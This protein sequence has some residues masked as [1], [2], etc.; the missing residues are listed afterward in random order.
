[1]PP[2]PNLVHLAV[3]SHET[4]PIAP[5]WNSTPH[6]TSCVI[7]RYGTRLIARSAPLRR[8]RDQQPE[9]RPAQHAEP[10]RDED[11]HERMP[12]QAP[13]GLP[14][15]PAD[16]Y[17]ERHRLDRGEHAKHR[18]LGRQVRGHAAA[19]QELPAPDRLLLDQFAN[20]ADHAEPHRRAPEN[21]HRGVTRDPAEAG[22]H[23]ERRQQRYR[24]P[25]EQAERQRQAGPARSAARSVRRRPCPGR[26]RARATRAT[27][28]AGWRHPSR[29]A[30]LR[31]RGPARQLR[32]VTR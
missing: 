8:R 3:K 20:R 5:S 22:R 26:A 23:R 19:C 18:H 16:H 12:E 2:S 13:N 4:K 6:S 9:G 11:R 28:R 15:H 27:R 7:S 21:E 17:G 24:H 32:S 30:S 14:E 29:R 10:G 31:R 1:M 25:L